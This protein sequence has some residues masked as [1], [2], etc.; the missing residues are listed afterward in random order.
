MRGRPSR[1]KA[2]A[3]VLVDGH[4]HDCRSVSAPNKTFPELRKLINS[5]ALDLL[6]TFTVESREELSRGQS[7]YGI[8]I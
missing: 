7:S 2:E 6:R 5:L 4:S 3:S 1:D 8:T